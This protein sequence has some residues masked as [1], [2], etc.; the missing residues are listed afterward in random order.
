MFVC[1]KLKT[2]TVELGSFIINIVNKYKTVKRFF[3]T[4]KLAQLSNFRLVKA[5]GC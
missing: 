5:R 3:Q 4:C 2:S 1:S